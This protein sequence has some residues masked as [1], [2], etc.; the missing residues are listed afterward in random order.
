MKALLALLL[1]VPLAAQLTIDLNPGGTHEKITLVTKA[2]NVELA[3]VANHHSKVVQVLGRTWTI[4]CKPADPV[5]LAQPAAIAFGKIRPTKGRNTVL[6]R[7]AKDGD[8]FKAVLK[9]GMSGFSPADDSQP[10]PGRKAPEPVKQADGAWT[11]TLADPLAAGD[12]ALI[13][14]TES[15]QFRVPA[16]S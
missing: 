9:E 15:W 8:S 13:S 10:Y 4:Y 11:L 16:G 2:G 14:D 3:P 6:V 1:S 12:Y 5:V 7:L